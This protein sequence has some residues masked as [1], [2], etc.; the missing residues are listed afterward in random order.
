MPRIEN[1]TSKTVIVTYSPYRDEV[2]LRPGRSADLDKVVELKLKPNCEVRYEG[3]V[4]LIVESE[5]CRRCRARPRVVGRT[6]CSICLAKLSRDQ[7]ARYARRRAAGLCPCAGCEEPPVPGRI[8]CSTH[9][10]ANANHVRR[11][12]RREKRG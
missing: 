4:I 5:T 6:H 11:A 7:M 10:A 2:T 8:K 1:M 9:L 3:D 12:Q